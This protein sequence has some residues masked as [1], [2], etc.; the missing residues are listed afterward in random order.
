M[1]ASYSINLNIKRKESSELEKSDLVWAHG[2]LRKVAG[3]CSV[4]FEAFMLSKLVT[5]GGSSTR[6]TVN[7]IRVCLVNDSTKRGL[8]HTSRSS[9]S[10]RNIILTRIGASPGSHQF[11]K[12]GGWSVAVRYLSSGGDTKPPSSDKVDDGSGSLGEAEEHA[13]SRLRDMMR[14]SPPSV[15]NEKD[16]T[17]VDQDSATGGNTGSNADLKDSESVVVRAIAGNALITTLKFAAWGSTGSS[18]MFGEAIH[19][20][21]DLGNQAIL[22]QGIREMQKQADSTHNY[23]YGRAA[24]FWGLVSACE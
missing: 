13:E 5:C 11:R 15:D 24:F 8:K 6:K 9:D 19:S 10:L 7:V 22:F 21:C 18:A 16:D 17:A 3:V 14:E 1:N 12:E 2:S 4:N 20:L 23:G